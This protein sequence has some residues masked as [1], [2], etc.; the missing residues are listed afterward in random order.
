MKHDC[1]SIRLA[2]LCCLLTVY[3]PVSAQISV[4]HLT[5]DHRQ[6]FVVVDEEPLL[7]WEQT[8]SRSGA[9]QIA[10]EIELNEAYSSKKILATGKVASG[11]SQNIHLK[12]INPQFRLNEGMYKWRL[13]VWDE[14]DNCS[15]WS[16]YQHLMIATAESAFGNSQWIGAITK[17]NSHLPEGRYFTGDTL[18]KANVKA[19]WQ[20]VDTLSRRSI[21]LKNNI[22]VGKKVKSAIVNVCGLGFYELTINGQKVGEGE[23]TPN[24]SDFDKSVF[25]NTYDVTHLL[26]RGHNELRAL[27]G[28]G[29]YNE[30]GGRYRKLLISFG[31]PTLRLCLTVTYTNGR[32][33]QFVTDEKWQWAESPLTFNSIYGG[34]D[35][36][37][38]LEQPTN[39]NPVVISEGPS[40]KLRPQL[41]YPVR[42]QETYPILRRVNA[43]LPVYDM[44]QNLAGFPR[45]TVK[46]KRG[47]TIRLTVAEKLNDDS[48]CDQ[49]QTGRPHYYEY[50]L[51]GDS[52]ETWHPRFSYYGFRYIQVEGA[53]LEGEV[54]PD[55]LPVLSDL[56][57][58]FV[59]NSA[60]KTSTFEC[61]NP[62][63]NTT[64]KIIQMAVRS[65]MQAVFTDC[66]HREKLGWLEQD[67]L[68]GEALAYN[69]DLAGMIAQE[70]QN[71]ADAQ[72]PDGS[73]PTT[74]PEYVVFKGR[75]VDDFAESP[76]WGMAFIYL[77]F[78]YHE[79][80]GDDRL[81]LRHYD[82]MR[83]YVDYLVGRTN[84]G[85]L[86]MGLGDWY[87]FVKGEKAGFAKNTPRTFVGTAHL[88]M[89][90]R[91]IAQAATLSGKQDDAAHYAQLAE[92]LRQA[93]LHEFWDDE[94]HAFR[95]NSQCAN[96][97][98]L[99]HGICEQK[100]REYVKTNLV[101]DI[102]AHGDRLTTGDV[103]NRFLFL[104]LVE[105]GE[106]ELLYRMI[107]HYDVPGYGYQ[108]KW[109]ATT[110]TE[111]WDPVQGSSLNHFM[112]GQIDEIFFRSLAGIE[113]VSADQVRISPRRISDLQYVKATTGTIYGPLT[114]EWHGNRPVKIDA[115]IGLT[116]IQ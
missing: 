83:R 81:I 77:P 116:I 110:L 79:R 40:G 22:Q 23:M 14:R 51:R 114:V 31:P 115:P 17:A 37:A 78:L 88:M 32:R 24:W 75:W 10:F 96:A 36:D 59:Y 111:Q 68:N 8:S 54:N 106:E 50:T 63:L 73:V 85:I 95:C 29:F 86:D 45:I 93:I 61:S 99:V 34:E 6:G 13:R 76:E 26:R 103:G 69:Y 92:T 102:H 87:D 5:C 104:A 38:R 72:R 113:F 105:E 25:Y 84:A 80:Y 9:R 1:L 82:G 33:Q 58:C 15:D 2:L 71:I 46:G 39:W 41:A 91:Y 16:D 47:Q 35:Y 30:Q 48:L 64:H 94:A 98:A 101:N 90:A 53:V 108:I 49:R 12:D 4:T 107:N 52:E 20:A 57:S 11:K 62:L 66:P 18:K 97:M 67:Y 44:G 60:P 112:M 70:V 100:D 56:R 74:A 21:Y 109:G 7:G 42:I 3:F 27:L 43:T 65:N 19:A 55:G 89:M 28:N